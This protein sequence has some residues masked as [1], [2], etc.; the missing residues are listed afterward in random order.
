MNWVRGELKAQKTFA[1]SDVF[2]GLGKRRPLER[3]YV[4]G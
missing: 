1:E 4:K 3:P 2:P